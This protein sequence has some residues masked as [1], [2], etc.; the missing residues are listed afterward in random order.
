[1]MDWF[2]LIFF[3]HHNNCI[4]EGNNFSFN[5]NLNQKLN[6]DFLRY[7]AMNNEF[8][9]TTDKTRLDIDL[10]HNFLTNEAYW[11]RGRSKEIVQ[12]S[13][14]NSLC[15]GAFVEDKQ[16]GFGR[17]V[18]DYAVFAWIMDV[19]ILDEYRRNGYGKKLMDTIMNYK[20]MQ[21]IQNWGLETDDAHGLYRKF[22]FRIARRPEKFMEIVS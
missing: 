20:A 22:G 5:Q 2:F 10:I 12:K 3:Y 9:I 1:M 16:V 13:I 18:T 19:F 7:P 17:V 8:E 4:V 11:A 21:S 14:D 6:P 15:F